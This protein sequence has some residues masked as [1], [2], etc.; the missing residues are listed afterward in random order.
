MTGREGGMLAEAVWNEIKLHLTKDR[1]V[2]IAKKLVFL[3]ERN[4][5]DTEA[6]APVLFAASGL[7]CSCEK[8]D[9]CGH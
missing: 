1:R 6:Y 4:D 5:A 8:G 7:P 3:F 9:A 2:S